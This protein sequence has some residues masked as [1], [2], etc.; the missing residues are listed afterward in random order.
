[1]KDLKKSKFFTELIKFTS[2]FDIIRIF[3]DAKNRIKTFAELSDYKDI[4]ELMPNKTDYVF[5]LTESEKNKGHWTLLLRRDNTFEYFDSYG[6]SPKKTLSFTP[7]YMN[8]FL[9]NDWNED[10]GKMLKSIVPPQ[11]PFKNYS[12]K[13]FQDI[14]IEEI[15]TCGRWCI[16]RLYLF[17][18]DNITNKEFEKIMKQQYTK[19]KGKLTYDEII[20]LIINI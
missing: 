9:G 4:Y 20:C 17:L 14:N 16:H 13:A 6:H 2:N 7:L 10:L 1:M 12:K 11:I 15:A 8:R 19:H 18:M 3:P 5:L